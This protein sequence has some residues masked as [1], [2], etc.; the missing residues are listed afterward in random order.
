MSILDDNRS[1]DSVSTYNAMRLE[2]EI[3]TKQFRNER[4]KLTVNL[5]YSHSW[6]M[7]RNN[8]LFHS[9][10]LTMQQYNILRILRGQH[11]KACNLQLLKE[12]MLDKQPDVS[13]LID[14]LVQKSLIERA[15]STT[16]RRKLDI[17]ISQSGLD[18]L[19]RM[20]PQVA[21]ADNELDALSDREV[22]E[23]NNLLDRLR[24]SK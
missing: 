11:P 3:K 16:D 20:E 6:L 8:R 23:L 15:T 21:V 18:L 22:A 5:I 17:V 24:D 1:A 19:A 9:Q 13:R 4:H 10:G 12:R 2:D 14:R 7:E